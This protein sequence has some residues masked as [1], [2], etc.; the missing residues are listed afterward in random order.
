MSR[1]QIASLVEGDGEV[2]ALPVLIRRVVAEIDPAVNPVVPRPWRQPATKILQP[3]GIEGFINT[4]A[5]RHPAHAIVVLL[6]CDDDCPRELG[7][8]LA[9]R[10]KQARPD[11]TTSLILAHREYESWFLAAAGSLA[12]K[13]RLATDLV[14]PESPE[15][16]RDAK[17]W[18][19]EHIEGAGIY[20]PTQD[21]AA[22]STILDLRRAHQRSRS[23]RKFWK[24]IKAIVQMA[25]SRS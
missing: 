25:E 15:N 9:S 4:V 12:G 5:E 21:Q 1:V 19:S 22:L 16:I 18:L 8:R 17:G 6:D 7:P 10:V 23:F 11:L 3:G 24:E 20:S 2:Q 14:A 13:R